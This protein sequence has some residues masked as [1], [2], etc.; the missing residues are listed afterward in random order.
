MLE[1]Q[2]PLP[3]DLQYVIDGMTECCDLDSGSALVLKLY[4]R[5]EI[6]DLAIGGEEELVG[7]GRFT[8]RIHRAH[9]LTRYA[10]DLARE[11]SIDR[12]GTLAGMGLIHK[13]FDCTVSARCMA[14]WSIGDYA[15]GGYARWWH[16]A[17][18]VDGVT[19]SRRNLR[20]LHSPEWIRRTVKH[21]R[22]TARLRQRH[23]GYFDHIAHVPPEAIAFDNTLWRAAF[24]VERERQLDHEQLMWRQTREN[25]DAGVPIKVTLKP[26]YMR[27]LRR[28]QRDQRKVLRRALAVAEGVLGRERALAFT[29]GERI[30]IEGRELDFHVKRNKTSSADPGHGAMSVMVVDKCGNGLARLCLYYQDTPALEQA[31]SL[32]LEVEAGGDEQAVLRTA[33]L[34]E[35]SSAGI[36]HPLLIERCRPGAINGPDPDEPVD[37]ELPTAG[38]RLLRDQ[39]YW[40]ETAPIWIEA[41]RTQVFGRKA[42]LLPPQQTVGY[43]GI[44]T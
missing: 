26:K 29:R 15:E 41:L 35:V 18:T 36:E 22:E 42:K 27:Q 39:A 32:A 6:I 28:H 21:D 1:V 11:L 8:Q 12:Q 30:E 7:M 5:R 38:K 23:A 4:G 20:R 3:P 19:P 25:M 31:V 43:E 40:A 37:V 14:E 17:Y 2:A 44:L 34:I 13:A 9:V 24:K 33:N 16:S 10:W